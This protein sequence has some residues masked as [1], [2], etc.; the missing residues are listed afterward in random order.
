MLVLVSF[1]LSI[2]Y[3]AQMILISSIAAM[4]DHVGPED[5]ITEQCWNVLSSAERNP[6]FAAFKLAEEA[7]W[8]LVEQLKGE[9]SI[10]CV[11]VNVR[12]EVFH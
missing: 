5:V 11:S 9:A 12:P 6:H 7:M 8:T 3:F 10:T 1:S 4:A 2:R